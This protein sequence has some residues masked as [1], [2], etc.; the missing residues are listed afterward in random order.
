MA[1]LKETEKK[2][3]DGQIINRCPRCDGVVFYSDD[4]IGNCINCGEEVEFI[5][6]KNNLVCCKCGAP[7]QVIYDSG[8]GLFLFCEFHLAEFKN[9]Q[10]PATGTKK[11]VNENEATKSL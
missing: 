11:A 3:K 6:D 8:E 4:E 10:A 1:Y 9:N 7:S 2:I 5:I